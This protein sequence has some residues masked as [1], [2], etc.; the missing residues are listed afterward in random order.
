MEKML[1]DSQQRVVALTKPKPGGIEMTNS[2]TININSST[3]KR[4]GTS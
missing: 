3:T 4:G 2:T 1:V